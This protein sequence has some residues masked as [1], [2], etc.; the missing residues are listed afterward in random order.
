MV[1]N[2]PNICMNLNLV[3]SG[4]SHDLVTAFPRENKILKK[5]IQTEVVKK[6]NNR[7]KGINRNINLMCEGQERYSIDCFNLAPSSHL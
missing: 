3:G 2:M 6:Y 5:I 4:F 7:N 1:K